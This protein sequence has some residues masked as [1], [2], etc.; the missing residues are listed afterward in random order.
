MSK[1][2]LFKIILKL[3]GI[4]L[5]LSLFYFISVLFSNF[6]LISDGNF[7]WFYLTAAIVN[8]GLLY[9]LVFEPGRI[10]SIFKLDQGFDDDRVDNLNLDSYI[11]TKVVLIGMATYLIVFNLADCISQIV[12]A[13]KDSVNPNQLDSLF[14]S[15]S[16][17]SAN[18]NLLFNSSLQIAIGFLLLTNHVR[19]SRWLEKLNK[20]NS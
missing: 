4:T 12:Y 9:I 10:V 5:V 2:D 3:Y 14:N 6:Q 16:P 19:L 18:Y 17:T 7:D 20:K 13:F 15:M 1:R 8:L 11:L